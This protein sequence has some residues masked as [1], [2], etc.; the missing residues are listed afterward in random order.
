[1]AFTKFLTSVANIAGLSDKP[2]TDDGLT[3]TQ[4][5][6]KFDKGATDIASYINNTLTTQID[7]DLATK[8][9][10]AAVVV[11]GLSAGSITNTYL[12]TDVKIGSLAALT[13]TLKT[14]V[15]GAINELVTSIA[16]LTG[17]NGVKWYGKTSQMS[18]AAQ[19]G[20]L[21]TNAV[22]SGYVTFTTEDVDDFS[23]IN[24]GTSAT[25]ITIPSG[26]SKVRFSIYAPMR[27]YNTTADNG[28]LT[29]YKNGISLENL[30][31]C[32]RDMSVRTFSSILS[33]SSGNYFELYWHSTGYG[34]LDAG[35]K[36]EMEVMS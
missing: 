29:L 17:N 7:I 2:N 6:V 10:L 36:F 4:L 13:T 21:Y 33:V 22:Q 15:V 28:S 25:R 9:E 3:S 12:A 20:D 14:S 26:V 19:I 30:I 11:G 34:Q 31:L 8:A 1:M 35:T 32:S 27:Q 24:I 5:K 23:A 16:T 18:G